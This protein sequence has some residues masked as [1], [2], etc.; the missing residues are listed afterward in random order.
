MKGTVV[1]YLVSNCCRSF[2]IFVVF[3]FSIGFCFHFVVVN[4]VEPNKKKERERSKYLIGTQQ[5]KLTEEERENTD[6][7]QLRSMMMM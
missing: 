5:K 4:F 1:G 3:F 7:S 2:C 6:M